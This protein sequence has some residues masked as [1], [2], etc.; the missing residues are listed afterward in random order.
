MICVVRD[1]RYQGRRIFFGETRRVIGSVINTKRKFE[2]ACCSTGI[3]SVWQA[4]PQRRC[5]GNASVD[6][7]LLDSAVS[8][9]TAI[10]QKWPMH[11][12]LVYA[13]PFYAGNHDLFFIDGSFCN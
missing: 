13:V 5:L 2:T 12:M 11:P 10:P 9:N 6:H 8:V 7:S 3:L 1:G 4:G